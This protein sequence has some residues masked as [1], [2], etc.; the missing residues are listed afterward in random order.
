[1]K[2]LTLLGVALVFSASVSADF[3]AFGVNARMSSNSI[4][5]SVADVNGNNEFALEDE[6]GM[7]DPDG[8]YFG[9]FLE[10][11]LP[12]IPN[13]AYSVTSM[14]SSNSQRPSSNV[15]FM[16]SEFSSDAASSNKFDHDYSDLTLYWNPLPEIIP[17]VGLNVG[18]TNRSYDSSFTMNNSG[19]SGNLVAAAAEELVIDHSLPLLFL[20]GRVDLP[21]VPIYVSA[22]YQ[23]ELISSYVDDFEI[24]VNDL[25]FEL[26]Y[27]L[28]AGLGV[29]LGSSSSEL[30][31][32][33]D[34]SVASNQAADFNLQTANTYLSAFFRF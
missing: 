16:G 32:D 8:S 7:D 20:G 15:T 2:K 25:S 19:S 9:A 21:V 11:P 24:S 23:R 12:I 27:K 13:I 22:N 6:L 31:I 26:G 18:I 34:S 5:S 14:S 4:T 29:A 28:F 3:L 17:F 1:M 33:A 30:D 10:H